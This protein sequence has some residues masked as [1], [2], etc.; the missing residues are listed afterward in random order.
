MYEKSTYIPKEFFI[1]IA[2]Y[3]TNASL[4]YVSIIY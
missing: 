4:M 1:H 2:T 3:I